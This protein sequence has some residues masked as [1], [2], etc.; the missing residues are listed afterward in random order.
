MQDR[1]LFY[2]ENVCCLPFTRL[3]WWRRLPGCC[4]G[5]LLCHLFSTMLC[6]C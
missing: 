3:G 2:E 1:K 6:G 5:I 4:Y